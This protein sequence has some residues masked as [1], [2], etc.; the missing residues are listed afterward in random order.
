MYL[1][2]YQK[3]EILKKAGNMLRIA[4]AQSVEFSDGRARGVRAFDVHSGSGFNFTVLADRGMDI[5]FA[6]YKG[7][8][9][10]WMSDAGI[11]APAYHE[12]TGRDFNRTFSGGLLTTCGLTQAGEPGVDSDGETLGLHGRISHTPAE[13]AH[14]ESFWQS[15]DYI[16]QITGTLK[17][18][19]H[20]SYNLAMTRQI[21]TAMNHPGLQLTDT[22]RNDGFLPAPLM[23]IYHFNLGFP[24]INDNSE[25]FSDAQAIKTIF[26]STNRSYNDLRLVGPKAE[27]SM[28][29][30]D[31]PL[32]EVKA[33]VINREL[34]FGIRFQYDSNRLPYL[35]QWKYL[36]DG[37][38][39]FALEPSNCYAWVGR[40]E[41]RKKDMLPTISPGESIS[42]SISVEIFPTSME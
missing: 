9:V 26:D 41:A 33:G 35:M 1:K 13:N 37:Y 19:N 2:Q 4:G 18:R 17:E 39:A 11:I 7:V 28:H 23:L 24:L 42:F 36:R 20:G 32:G 6:D 16:T 31:M 15:D 29:L 22:I 3:Q 27:K 10:G 21:T 14:A 12:R 40:A 5:A 25:V 8:P 38:Y 30:H 34:Q